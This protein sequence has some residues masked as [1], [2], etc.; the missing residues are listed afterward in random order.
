MKFIEVKIRRVVRALTLKTVASAVF[1]ICNISF[2]LASAPEP[3]SVYLFSYTTNKNNNRNGLHFAWSRDQKAWFLIGDEFRFLRCDFGGGSNGKRM[4]NPFL[5]LDR[6][7]KWHCVW[8]IGEHEGTFAHASSADL[9][10]WGRQDYPTVFAGLHV[11]QPVVKWNEKSYSI[12]FMGK[13]GQSYEMTTENFKSYSLAAKVDSLYSSEN[14]DVNL[15][16]GNASG[17]IHRV[18]WTAVEKLTHWTERSNYQ[19]NLFSERAEQDAQRFPGLQPIDASFTLDISNPKR[20]SDLLIGVFFEDI[21]YAADGGLYAE[22]I[23]NRGFEYK[24]SDRQYKDT[25]W[26]SRHSWSV[27][28]RGILTI[29]SLHAIHPNNPHYGALTSSDENASLVNAGFDGIS[30]AKGKTFNFSFFVKRLKGEARSVYVSLVS[31]DGR[32]LASA[33]VN[34]DYGNWRKV[35]TAFT[36][37]DSATAASLE[38]QPIGAGTLAVDMISLFPSDTF[39]GRKNGLR[40]DLAQTIADIHPKFIRFPGGCVAHG[41]GLGNVYRWKNTIGPLES[42][43]PQRNIWGYHQTAGLGYFEYFQFC[44]DIGAI[45]LPVLAAG[46]PCQNSTVGGPGQQ[47]GLPLDEMDEYVQE[48]LD[49]IEYANGSPESVWGKLRAEAGHPKP[50]NLKYIGIGNEDLISDIFEERFKLIFDAVRKKYPEVTVI[51]TVGP[52]YEGT[53]YTEGWKLA[54][55]L[56][57][58]VVDEHYYQTPGWFIHNQEFYDRYDRSSAKVYLGEYASHIPGRHSTIETALT[59]ALYLTSLE[60]NGDVVMM[61]S[62][63]PLLAKTDHTQWSPDLIYFDNATVKPTVGY[64]V[65]KLFGQNSGDTYLPTVTTLSDNQVAVK[66]RVAISVVKDSKTGDVIVKLVNLLPVEIR[67]V[68]NLAGFGEFTNVAAKT[69][70][71]GDPND[72]KALPLESV[73]NIENQFSLNLDRYSLTV[74]R[75]QRR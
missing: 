21:N 72:T 36:A 35:S 59:E 71:K 75:L 58:P 53:D 74:I 4:L 65:Q 26:H 30:V 46:V 13:P 57:I 45:P 70:L 1:G 19:S 67:S 15:P 37:S 38:I 68:V 64:H 49:L 18:P 27:K 12:L 6:N 66:K 51:G 10:S 9:I 56:N 5:F 50:F 41:D 31:S 25:T 55:T 43:N 28:G 34:V 22:L 61:S 62:Y 48:V 16:T 17:Q 14:V 60:R 33:K 32:K 54:N 39:K 2:A 24:R 73:I 8:S 52:S 7:D 44:E 23:Q 40:K 47:G 11:H 69:I 20:I 29:D 63:A 3:D 42:R